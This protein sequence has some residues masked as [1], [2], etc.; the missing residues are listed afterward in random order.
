VQCL[1]GVSTYELWLSQLYV[2]MNTFV[3]VTKKVI[4]PIVSDHTWCWFPECYALTNLFEMLE[5]PNEGNNSNKRT[6][7]FGSNT[8]DNTTATK[9][10]DSECFKCRKSGHWSASTYVS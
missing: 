8:N 7:S 4:G 6:K 3:S 1:E 5:C 9:A 2:L 10:G